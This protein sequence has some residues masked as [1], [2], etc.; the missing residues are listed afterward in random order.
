MN[1]QYQ[2]LMNFVFILKDVSDLEK[3]GIIINEV[4][5]TRQDTCRISEMFLL[6]K[7]NYRKLFDT[8]LVFRLIVLDLSWASI[9]AILEILNLETVE[10]YANRIFKYSNGTNEEHS[11]KHQS[12]LSSCVSHTMHRFTRGLKRQVKFQNTESRTFSVCCFSLLVNS[13]DLNS[14]KQIFKLMCKVFT[15]QLTDDSVSEAIESLQA[16]IQLRPEGYTEIKKI[17]QDVFIEVEHD[18]KD[19]QEDEADNPCKNTEDAWFT[20]QTTTIKAASPFT[21]IY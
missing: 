20:E 21:K 10:Q 7:H 8:T 1:D 6:L 4:I 2:Q 9:H 3:P 11:T 5:T 16:L 18:S 17:I 13:I 19:D 12:F 14:S 15:N